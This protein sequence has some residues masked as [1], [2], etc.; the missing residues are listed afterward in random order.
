M[1]VTA[2]EPRLVVPIVDA[3]IVHGLADPAHPVAERALPSARGPGVRPLP[4]G[5]FA[6]LYGRTSTAVALAPPAGGPADVVASYRLDAGGIVSSAEAF[7]STPDDV[8]AA[9][10]ADR[11]GHVAERKTTLRGRIAEMCTAV[12]AGAICAQR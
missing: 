6:L 5:T 2:G 4:G 9:R 10:A 11:A 12:P 8:I 3:V 1:I 7:G